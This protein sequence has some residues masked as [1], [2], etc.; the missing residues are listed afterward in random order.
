MF[1]LFKKKGTANEL[2]A[3]ANGKVIPIEEVN[4]EVF[5]SCMLGKGIAVQPA[6]GIVMAPI[7]GTISVTMEGTN[8]AVGINVADGFDL[9]IHIGIDTVSLNGEGFTAH[10]KT[11]DKVKAGCKLVTFDKD[12]VVA[13]G[14][15][16]DVMMIALDSPGLPKLEY[17]TGIDSRA[18]ETVIAV[19]QEYKK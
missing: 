15:C 4:D 12:L 19:W 13:K 14:L 3:P 16:P 2:K 18:G 11:G 17:K 10:V 1:S 5:S 7:D 6:D 8:H 9:L